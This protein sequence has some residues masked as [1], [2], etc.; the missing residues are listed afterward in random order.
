MIRLL[1]FFFLF[2]YSYSF[3]QI[4]NSQTCRIEF[5]LL[6]MVRP[7]LDTTKNLRGEFL[8]TK[9][10]L[11]D[12]AF[13]KDVEIYSYSILRDTTRSTHRQ[14]IIEEHHKFN[15]N[16]A[17]THR[18]NNLNIPLC[19]G[20]QFAL[21][22]NGQIAYVGYFWN[23]RSSFGS[24]WITAFS[25]NTYIDVMRK[26]PDY[27]FATDSNDPRINHLL[28]ECLNSTNRLTK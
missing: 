24:D 1:T 2:C 16:N 23:L 22:V 6:K 11:A 9:N 26:L 19:C 28:F 25:H 14:N 20:R 8:V 5:Y 4:E 13:I 7:N 15:V 10:D 18:I 3:G 17:T 27:D 21:V 12:T